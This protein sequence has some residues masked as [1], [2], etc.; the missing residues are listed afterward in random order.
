MSKSSPVSPAVQPSAPE[1]KS[2]Y[3]TGKGCLAMLAIAL[4]VLGIT[5]LL[6]YFFAQPV[7]T[8]H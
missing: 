8:A 4:A 3:Q 1:G 6:M 2:N 5:I 7:T